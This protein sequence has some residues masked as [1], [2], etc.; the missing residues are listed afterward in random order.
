MVKETPSV[1]LL[2]P[3]YP[4]S[5]EEELSHLEEQWKGQQPWW[6]RWL[7]W[8]FCWRHNAHFKRLGNQSHNPTVSINELNR[9]LGGD[10][11]CSLYTLQS[12]S[13]HQTVRQL[14]PK[15]VI[16][17]FPI[18]LF[19]SKWEELL[20]NR[21][22]QTLIDR[23]HSVQLIARPS[24]TDSWLDIV[25]QWIRY[26]IITHS[27]ETPIQHVV[28]L[29]RRQ[30]EHWNGFDSTADKKRYLLEK[31]LSNLFPTC[32]VQVLLNAPLSK[33]F[34]EKIPKTE[35][36]YYG[37][38]DSLDDN[39]DTLHPALEHPSLRPLKQ[40]PENILLLR[41]LRQSIWDST[42]CAP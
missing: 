37:F 22:R 1:W 13:L 38:L 29:M 24:T 30:I 16:H 4:I 28:L 23:G 21:L 9:L 2:L 25:A 15:S 41:I 27:V 32:T 20:L 6:R 35:H 19:P 42:G 40:H 18:G 26:N 7:W 5:A 8:W 3:S 17:L 31:E 33:S 10:A 39:R 34:L 36:I 14:A 11:K 12:E